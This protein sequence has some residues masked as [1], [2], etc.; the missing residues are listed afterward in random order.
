MSS[1]SPR[2]DDTLGVPASSAKPE[3]ALP[4]S[5]IF[6]TFNIPSWKADPYPSYSRC[7]SRPFDWATR[8]QK[9]S[10]ANSISHKSAPLSVGRVATWC[11]ASRCKGHWSIC[12]RCCSTRRITALDSN[13]FIEAPKNAWLK[14]RKSQGLSDV[15]LP[16]RCLFVQERNLRARP[17]MEKDAPPAV[18]TSFVVNFLVLN[19]WDLSLAVAT[20]PRRVILL[21]WKE[22]TASSGWFVAIS[23]GFGYIATLCHILP[24][25][26]T[27]LQQVERLCSPHSSGW[28]WKNPFAVVEQV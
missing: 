24:F 4:G 13:P 10:E 14:L 11:V 7:K 5:Q 25:C 8:P 16:F 2:P 26:A 3:L 21:A 23:L 15:H 18:E 27:S 17:Y 28:R 9:E 22:K 1:A 6:Q 12:S 20:F 19:F